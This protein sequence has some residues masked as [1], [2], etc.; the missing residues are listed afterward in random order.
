MMGE[1]YHGGEMASIFVRIHRKRLVSVVLLHFHDLFE[2][3]A[4]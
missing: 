3:Y 4:F 2:K 1:D